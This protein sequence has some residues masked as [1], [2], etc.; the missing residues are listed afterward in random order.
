M[1]AL[2]RFAGRGEISKW[3][4]AA[5]AAK[6]YLNFL[7]AFPKGEA[8]DHSVLVRRHAAEQEHYDISLE[9]LVIGV[10]GGQTS[11]KC[12]LAGSD[13]TVLGLGQ[14]SGLLHLAAAGGPE[15][16]L[17]SLGEAV[18]Q[19]WSAAGRAPRPVA[20]LAMGLTGVTS[21]DTPEAA[22]AV[23]LAGRV[24]SA[25]LVCA[26]ND[27][28]PALKG[29]HGGQ[30]GIICIAGTGAI[31]LGV[32]AAGR[33]ERAGGWGWLLGD[34]GS[35]FWI[36]REGLRA[37]LRAQEGLGLPSALLAA[38]QAHFLVKDMIQVK[39]V[40]FGAGFAAQGFAA[41]AALVAVAADNGDEV[42]AGI[43]RQ[44]GAELAA[45]VRAVARRL[46]FGAQPVPVAP[47]GG[48]F[49]HFSLLRQAF[50]SE[51]EDTGAFTL[52]EPRFSPLSGA[53]IL[54]RELAGFA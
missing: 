36:G 20:A 35:A 41:L 45:A 37:A 19:A 18:R 26:D 8:S 28:L 51:V 5:Y 21:A 24:V 7:S 33:L 32:D 2:K 16:F 40:V 17:E 25:A 27:A 39:R 1:S 43:F 10:D 3:F 12:A 38:F 31:T 46:D 50:K 13:G 42:A 14:G 47:V 23:Q 53:V 9:P 48:A 34:E 49:E 4:L 22:L 6:N 29:A 30:P 11:L 15:R 54:A 52:V 44:A